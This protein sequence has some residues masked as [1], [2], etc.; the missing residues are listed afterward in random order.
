M[1]ERENNQ[2]WYHGSQQLFRTLKAGSSITQDIAIARAF[3]HR[4]S[5]MAQYGDGII[6]HDGTTPGYLHRVAEEIH[7]ED[8]FPHPHPVNVNHWE[9][10]TTRELC[11]ELIEQTSPRLSQCKTSPRYDEN[12]PRREP[13]RSSSG[14]IMTRDRPS[15][16]Y[17]AAGHH[18]LPS[19]RRP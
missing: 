4:P 7:A 13:N 8:I 3:S 11:V 5:L 9:W 19:F 10:L 12:R 15:D 16:S 6:K 17:S 18:L 2:P 1:A 14:A